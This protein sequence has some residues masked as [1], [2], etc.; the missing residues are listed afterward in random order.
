M[1]LYTGPTSTCGVYRNAGPCVKR[2]CT[3]HAGKTH[4]LRGSFETNHAIPLQPNVL[5]VKMQAYMVLMEF[6]SQLPFSCER[7]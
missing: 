6:R 2:I 1:L 5:Y 3:A 7:Y 4:L